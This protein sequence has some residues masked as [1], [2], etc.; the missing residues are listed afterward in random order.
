MNDWI[1]IAPM[2]AF[3]LLG[4]AG[5]LAAAKTQRDLTMALT[6]YAAVQEEK[7]LLYSQNADLREEVQERR[8][9]IENLRHERD[10]VQLQLSE[11]LLVPK[12][13]PVRVKK[14]EDAL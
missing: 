12:A 8:A 3:A 4:F 14:V 9:E 13:R 5:W 11:A 2:A 6:H 10:T 7:K 1:L